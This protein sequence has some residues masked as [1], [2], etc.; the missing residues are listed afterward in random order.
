MSILTKIPSENKIEKEVKK[1]L[2]PNGLRCPYCNRKWHLRYLVKEKRYFCPKCRKKFSF[3]SISWL[4]HSKLKLNDIYLVIYLWQKKISPQGIKDL[5]RLSKPTIVSFLKKL[6]ENI[7][8]ETVRLS[9]D[10]QVDESFFGRQRYDNQLVVIGA[11][12]KSGKVGFKI[13]PDREQDTI[14]TFIHE[15]IVPYSIVNLDYHSSYQG[16]ET[17]GYIHN[18]FNHSIGHFTGTNRIE[19]VWSVIK[20]LIRK[21]YNRLL[22]E[23][24]PY[25]LKEFQARFNHKEYFDNPLSYLKISLKVVP[26]SLL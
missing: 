8:E 5:T 23:Y 11:K 19:N 14:E 16:L 12:E 26:S 25:Y 3:K 4:K 9:G 10:V 22:K 13:I 18:A 20:R 1:I 2:F 17:L 15:T 7:P 21:M 6:R 24:L